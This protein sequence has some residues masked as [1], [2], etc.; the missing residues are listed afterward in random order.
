V[1]AIL[2]YRVPQLIERRRALSAGMPVNDLRAALDA[3]LL[4][5]VAMGED[6]DCYYLMFLEQL[7]RHGIG[8]HPFDAL[9]AAYQRTQR[10]FVA[11]VSGMLEKLPKQLRPVRINQ[12]SSVC[13]HAAADRQRAR[14]F[15]SPTLPYAL[16][17]SELFSS[18]VAM[19]R[20]PVSRETL[21]ALADAPA[22]LAT[23]SV[24]L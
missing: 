3:H 6:P 18:L 22:R 14:H 4:P 15:G 10:D 12:A 9:P 5:V 8:A 24:A 23:G 7:M 17:V 1:R 2:A 11:R 20:Q 13:L 21:A 16:Y 19:L